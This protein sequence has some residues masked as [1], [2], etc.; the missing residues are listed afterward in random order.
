[1]EGKSYFSE[2]L[3][4]ILFL[5]IKKERLTRL[6][7]VYLEDNVYMPI[8]STSLIEKIKSGKALEEIPAASFVE[9][10]FYVIG[11][12]EAFKYASIYREML[13]TLPNSLSFIKGAIFNA[14]KQEKLEEAY[15][16][17]KGLVQLEGNVE[18]FDRLLSLAEGIRN[19]DK[20]FKN[21]EVYLIEKAKSIEDYSAPY[22]YE[23]IIK[24][25]DGDFEGALFSINN[26]L[27]RG[28]EKTPE[29]IE[30]VNSLKGIVN[31]ERGKELL[32]EDA[33]AAL[34]LLIPLLEEYGDNATLYY[35][36]AVGYRILENF[37]K[38]IHYLN[39]ALVIDDALVE[40]VNELG[41]NYASIGD[42]EKAIQ[43][44]RKAFDATKSV[45]IC[46][47]LVMCYLNA[48]DKEQA[49]NH[50]EIAKKLDENDE[51]V[52]ELEKIIK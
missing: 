12:D 7:N 44:L 52:R 46:T 21:E 40:V 17:L 45:E 8:K 42:F 23:A 43:Y 35:H 2:R 32:Y 14:V 20:T 6:F 22:L 28:G 47:N 48:G 49:K 25:D 10:M 18:N 37:E 29:V 13:L 3:G 11:L 31:Y 41:I 38:A 51:I 9:G 39:E 24:R 30:F 1:M 34:K 19:K 5:D 50:F 26:Y 4:S 15:I 27:N 16:F 33:D 36:I